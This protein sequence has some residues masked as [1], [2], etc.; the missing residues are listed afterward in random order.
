MSSDILSRL[1]KVQKAALIKYNAAQEDCNNLD[2]YANV[3]EELENDILDKLS[4]AEYEYQCACFDIEKYHYNL[5]NNI[6]PE[7]NKYAV[8]SVEESITESV[9]E[10]HIPQK[11]IKI[12]KDN[13]R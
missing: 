5:K 1:E 6:Y 8:K 7:K 13:N 2:Y 9:E 3:P 4:D 12:N 10:L 11:R